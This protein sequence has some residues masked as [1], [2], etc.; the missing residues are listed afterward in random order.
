MGPFGSAPQPET[1]VTPAGDAAWE[2]LDQWYELRP[3]HA[4]L[5]ALDEALYEATKV[6]KLE[7]NEA[8]LR[9][10]QDLQ[11]DRFQAL[12]GK[13][14]AMRS[15]AESD[16]ALVADAVL[17]ISWTTGDL[18]GSTYV[19]GPETDANNA[20]TLPDGR[21]V[22]TTKAGTIM[23]IDGTVITQTAL[24]G[25]ASPDPKGVDSP[26]NFGGLCYPGHGSVVA[27]H[28]A[29]PSKSLIVGDRLLVPGTAFVVGYDV[30]T[31]QVQWVHVKT[32]A[33]R[34][35]AVG[36]TCDATLVYFQDNGHAVGLSMDEGVVVWEADAPQHTI[37]LR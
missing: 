37:Q 9:A 11:S 17:R 19:D 8:T 32:N 22:A 12:E 15:L 4:R 34:A 25:E 1:L 23:V 24:L 3:V 5:A 6:S 30:D 36:L 33:D 10:V 21:I 35:Y 26:G 14:S 13:Q 31:G 27:L 28:S 29:V 2:S 20:L 18:V 7:P 16:R